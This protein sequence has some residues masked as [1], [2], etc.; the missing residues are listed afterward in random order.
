MILY[1]DT[2]ALVKRYFRE[3]YSDDVL[4]RWKSA[5]QIVTSFVAYAETMASICR[6]KLESDFG[7]TLIRKIVGT[8]HQDWES[9]IRVEVN[10]NL[11]EY[12]DRVV[13]KYP[14]RGFDAIHL[15]SAMVIHERLPQ[16]FI[17]AC[18]DDRLA[19]AAQSEGFETFPPEE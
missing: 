14:L 4:S 17:F 16:D 1:L 18:F 2:S 8:F 7:D 10:G 5:T 13:G 11:N 6:K 19:R 15:A 12:I 3:P 9:F